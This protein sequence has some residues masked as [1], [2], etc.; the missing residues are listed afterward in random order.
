ME[1]DADQSR[2]QFGTKY[3][4]RAPEQKLFA[5]AA[6]VS[7]STAGGG[8]G[9]GGEVLLVLLV[10]LLICLC[11]MVQTNTMGKK[12]K[13]NLLFSNPPAAMSK[14]LLRA[15]TNWF[16]SSGW[17][18]RVITLAMSVQYVHA[19]GCD[20]D[21]C[22]SKCSTKWLCVDDVPSACSIFQDPD[23][24]SVYGFCKG[25]GHS[26]RETWQCECTWKEEKF[27][28]DSMGQRCFDDY[29]NQNC[30]KLMAVC[31]T[32]FDRL[33]ATERDRTRD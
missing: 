17:V 10:V 29:Q 32:C 21:P 14:Q 13:N 24:E 22:Q 33:K 1:E 2:Q 16:V 7:C 9:G 4:P 8:G 23:G 6:T 26:T 18:A 25:D 31:Q 5:K 30:L 15:S 12:I 28:C 27:L 20:F 3:P 19:D 11:A